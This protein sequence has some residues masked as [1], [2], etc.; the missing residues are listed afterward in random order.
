MCGIA[1]LL[2]QD[3]HRPV[4]PGVIKRMGDSL[5]HRGPDSEGFW[6]GSGVALAHRRLSIVDP[7][8]GRQPISNEDDSV[9]VIL[10]G[11]IYNYKHLRRRLERKGHVFKTNT[12]TEILSARNRCR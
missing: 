5:T 8:G 6:L 12:D 11:E 2:Y 9:Q 3:A 4:V 1:G 7:A 10:N